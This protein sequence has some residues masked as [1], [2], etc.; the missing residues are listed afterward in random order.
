MNHGTWAHVRRLLD[1]GLRPAGAGQR[2][3]SAVAPESFAVISS[4]PEELH[5]INDLHN[6]A[7]PAGCSTAPIGTL[8]WRDRGRQRRRYVPRKPVD[9]TRAALEQR[10]RLRPPA[11]S[12]YPAVPVIVVTGS[13]N[14]EIAR[15]ARAGGALS[16]VGKPFNLET[17]SSVVASAI[18]MSRVVDDRRPGHVMFAWRN[19]V[20]ASFPIAAPGAL[21]ASPSCRRF[22][23]FS[24]GTTCA[25]ALPRPSR[26]YRRLA[27]TRWGGGRGHEEGRWER[28]IQRAST[29]GSWPAAIRKGF[30][31]PSHWSSGG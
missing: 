21:V 8:P 23:D 10:R 30:A 26:A 4:P 17:L 1:L 20:S 29:A 15:Q 6:A 12:L 28:V 27:V 22:T 19:R 25:A 14:E 18:G 9:A 13:M 5:Q 7:A 11:W 2:L 24:V 16:I 31:A 3:D